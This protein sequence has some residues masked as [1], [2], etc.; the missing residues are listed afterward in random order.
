MRTRRGLAVYLLAAGLIGCG[1]GDEAEI[2][3]SRPSE[4]G[5]QKSVKRSLEDEG[6]VAYR[7]YCVGCHGQQGDGNGKAA[8]FLHPK[9]RDF[10][11]ANFKFSSTRSGQLPTD[12]DL[13]RTIRQGLKGSAMPP[14]DLLPERTVNALIAYLKTFSLRWAERGPG[15]PIPF[16]EDPYRTDPDKST[17]IRRGEAVYHGFATCWNCHPAYVSAEMLNEYPVEFGGLARDTFR[18]GLD[19]SVAK[20]NTEGELVYPPDFLRDYVRAGADLAALYRAIGA[21]IT[22]TAM[23]TWIDSMDIPGETAADPPLVQPSDIWAMA[24]Y[25]QDL[26]RQRPPKLAEGTFRVRERPKQIY[27][28]GEPPA[29]PTAAQPE[30]EAEEE[31]FED[32]EEEYEED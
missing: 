3:T 11:R 4:F 14:F 24:Y 10:V 21:G 8:K 5:F 32:D 17:A 9:P 12:A 31:F 6:K 13:K 20:P 27:L 30:L 26:I 23:P 2:D 25:V 18:A 7:K 16:V 29:P 1:S 15:T 28:R 22:G 19:Q